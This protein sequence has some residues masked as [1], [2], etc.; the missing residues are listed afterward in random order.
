M[1]I[2]IFPKTSM[3]GSSAQPARDCISST[4]RLASCWRSKEVRPP[5]SKASF[6]GAVC[7]EN[8]IRVY[9]AIESANLGA[10]IALVCFVLAVL[11]SPFRSKI[12]LEAENA[13]LRQQL[14]V[15]RRK[16]RRRAPSLRTA[17]GGSSFSS[18]AGSHRSYRFSQSSTPRPW[19]AGI[20]PAFVAIGVGNRGGGEGDRRSRQNCAR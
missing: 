1:A 3:R 19:C 10:I 14:I 20:G 11:A 18:I 8:P 16:V 4:E 6:I 2:Q 12:R 9:W 5:Q 7:T 15:L 17:I 13:A